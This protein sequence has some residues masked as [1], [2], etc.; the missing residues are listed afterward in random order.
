MK[1]YVEKQESLVP[2]AEAIKQSALKKGL[3][4][5]PIQIPYTT[6]QVNRWY[7]A[8]ESFSMVRV[9]AGNVNVGSYYGNLDE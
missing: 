5:L 3:I 7:K 6:K 2:R 4:R 8:V 9:P 1:Y